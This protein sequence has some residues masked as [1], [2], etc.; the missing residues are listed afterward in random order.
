[1]PGVGTPGA[2]SQGGAGDLPSSPSFQTRLGR[3]W[4]GGGRWHIHL[5][6]HPGR[7]ARPVLKGV[8][9]NETAAPLHVRW[10]CRTK[11][12]NKKALWV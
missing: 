1:M 11:K 2:T 7:V 8:R 5:A 4:L 3:G 12:A 6:G 9:E 10:E